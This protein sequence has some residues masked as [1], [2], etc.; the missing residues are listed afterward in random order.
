MMLA[1]YIIGGALAYIF[2]GVVTAGVAEG[3]GKTNTT[4]TE[5]LS[6][7]T[8]GIFW[9]FTLAVVLVGLLVKGLTVPFQK[10]YHTTVEVARR[11]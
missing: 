4:N 7:E 6:A 2:V 11:D 9:P 8:Y 5:N 1:L 3:K 10:I